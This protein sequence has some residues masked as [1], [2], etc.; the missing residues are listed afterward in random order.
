MPAPS[1][2]D[3]LAKT[4]DG[5]MSLSEHEGENRVEIMGLDLLRQRHMIPDILDD[6][7]FSDDSSTVD[8]SYA[9]DSLEIARLMKAGKMNRRLSN[10][11][12][13]NDSV[14]IAKNKSRRNSERPQVPKDT[15]PLKAVLKLSDGQIDVKNLPTSVGTTPDLAGLK[16]VRISN[17]AA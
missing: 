4:F 13:A 14:E 10:D 1:M 7:S 5:Q 16:P 3:E 15:V 12:F 9:N 2:V 6:I 17:S 11:S 8:E